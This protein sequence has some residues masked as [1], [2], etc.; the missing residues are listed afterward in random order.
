M[1]HP[2][3]ESEVAIQAV[4]NSAHRKVF[5]QL[6]GQFY[7]N[8]PH[9]VPRLYWERWLAFSR[10]NPF[11][12]HGRWQAWIAYRG[13]CPVGRI[14]AQIDDLEKSQNR[15]RGYFGLLEAEDNQET[16]RVLLKTA[17]SWLAERGIKEIVGPMNLNINQ[18]IGLLV[19]GFESPP[20]LMTPHTAPWFAPRVE[21]C[22]YETAAEALA[23]IAE[24]ELALKRL[25][26]SKKRMLAVF[27][28]RSGY[29]HENLV[30]RPINY[31]RLA[32]ENRT[33]KGIFDDAWSE[34]W[35]F[36]PFGE[37]ELR[38]NLQKVRLLGKAEL[39]QI[40]EYESEAV[41]FAMLVPNLNEVLHKLKSR[42][43]PLGWLKLL[44]C[45]GTNA[46]QT[47]RLPLMGIRK[48]F[49]KTPLGTHA[50]QAL[51]SAIFMHARQRRMHSV[52][53]SW[54]LK[55]NRQAGSSAVKMTNGRVHKTYRM[56]RK[57]LQPESRQ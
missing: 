33:I 35:G 25:E 39:I 48:K 31:S 9:W 34:N 6:A 22:G 44:W 55:S 51:L 53:M 20:Y 19:E 15:N 47:G 12:E 5:I 3:P 41:G 17:E 18:E 37:K 16:F 57:L 49:H 36:V 28:R 42:L 52:E 24:T 56:Y 8:D 27:N 14:S 40:A 43:L 21:A 54:I 45:L 2:I 11:F 1:I 7:L 30:V 23:F 46:I 50:I 26:E 13:G 10:R 38:E 4:S 32:D 29:R